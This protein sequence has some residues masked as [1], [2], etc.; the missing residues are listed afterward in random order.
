MHFTPPGCA[1]QAAR[2][3]SVAAGER[4]A[5]ID[6]LL[7]QVG[8]VPHALKLLGAALHER[9]LL[10]QDYAAD[11]DARLALVKGLLALL[12]ARVRPI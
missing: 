12:P 5:A 10:I 8:G 6:A 7:T 2:C 11:T 3:G 9:G 4:R 1:D